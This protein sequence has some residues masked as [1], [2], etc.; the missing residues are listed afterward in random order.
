M[1]APNRVLAYAT[2][3]WNNKS[4]RICLDEQELKA[5]KL[6]LEILSAVEAGDYKFTTEEFFTHFEDDGSDPDWKAE[7]EVLESMQ[8]YDD[9]VKAPG[10]P[11][12]IRFGEVLVD[13]DKVKEAVEFYG[14]RKGYLNNG[15]RIRPPLA[16]MRKRFSFIKD[17]NHLHKIRDYETKGKIQKPSSNRDETLLFQES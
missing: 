4:K 2:D 15:S 1:D 8:V 10:E 3:H 7:D 13:L 9:V 17:V 6:I 5:A 16:T 12:M 14:S 11:N